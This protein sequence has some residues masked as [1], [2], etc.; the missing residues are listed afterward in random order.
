MYPDKAGYFVVEAARLVLRGAWAVA[1]AALA[2]FFLGDLCAVA[3][4]AVLAAPPRFLVEREAVFVLLAAGL[5]P[6]FFVVAISV[7][8]E[9]GRHSSLG[10]FLGAR[11]GEAYSQL[12]K[13]S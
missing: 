6:V 13:S 1:L 4:A 5:V 3:F 7:A 10:F 9:F 11:Q 12:T 2:G 8:P